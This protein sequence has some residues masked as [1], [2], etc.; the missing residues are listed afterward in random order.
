MIYGNFKGSLS[1]FKLLTEL[2]PQSANHYYGLASILEQLKDFKKA[3]SAYNRVIE[4]DPSNLLAK[5]ARDKINE[6]KN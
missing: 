2:Y 4:I 3:I 5:T 1:V 6:L